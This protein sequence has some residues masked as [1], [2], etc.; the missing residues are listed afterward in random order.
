LQGR[1]IDRLFTVAYLPSCLLLLALTMRFNILST[2]CTTGSAAGRSAAGGSA[3]GLSLST[4]PGPGPGQSVGV[5]YW[6]Q[7]WCQ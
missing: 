3:A 7:H 1:H 5:A 6:K 4:G 2:R